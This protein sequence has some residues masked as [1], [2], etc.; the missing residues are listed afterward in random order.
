MA[1]MKNP[2]VQTVK[3]KTSL[4]FDS[5]VFDNDFGANPQLSSGN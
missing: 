3:Q 2:G 5:E 4:S 1:S